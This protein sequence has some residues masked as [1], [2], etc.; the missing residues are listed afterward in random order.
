MITLF[1]TIA[2]SREVQPAGRGQS[3]GRIRSRSPTIQLLGLDVLP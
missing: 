3:T 1:D 2:K